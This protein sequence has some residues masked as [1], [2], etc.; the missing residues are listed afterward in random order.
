MVGSYTPHNP[1][2]PTDLDHPN[3]ELMQSASADDDISAPEHW[4]W[5][6]AE[7]H[8]AVERP[9]A[10]ITVRV[11][12]DDLTMLLAAASAAGLT[13]PAYVRAAALEKALAVQH[14]GSAAR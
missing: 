13:L 6:S 3:P 8:P 7:V 12:G 14:A 5:D 1:E 4:D 9:G 2:L 11:E 10:R